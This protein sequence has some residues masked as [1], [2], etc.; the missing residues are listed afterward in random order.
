MFTQVG[1]PIQQ[2]WLRAVG[3]VESEQYFYDFLKLCCPS[4][5]ASLFLTVPFFKTMI[6]STSGRKPI[7][8]VTNILDNI[9]LL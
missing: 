2:L 8:W 7:P 5:L 4:L 6:L 1:L 9:L 3:V